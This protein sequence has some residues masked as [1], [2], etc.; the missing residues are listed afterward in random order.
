[1]RECIDGPEEGVLDPGLIHRRRS[2]QCHPSLLHTRVRSMTLT[3]LARRTLFIRIRYAILLILILI[4]ANRN[5]CS[6]SIRRNGHRWILSR[7]SYACSWWVNLGC[8]C[9]TW[10]D[11][12]PQM[13]LIHWCHP[14]WLW[15]SYWWAVGI[16]ASS[17]YWISSEPNRINTSYNMMSKVKSITWQN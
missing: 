6:R 1:M 13:G 3:L 9:S 5:R 11:G 10:R 4:S 16:V 17:V 8:S 7:I 14:L 12:Y 2:L 15:F